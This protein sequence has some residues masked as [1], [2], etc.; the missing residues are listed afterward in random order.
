MAPLKRAQTSVDEDDSS[1]SSD[2]NSNK[3][4]RTSESTSGFPE[5]EENNESNGEE[6]E[7]S[8]M[9]LQSFETYDAEE[10]DE[11]TLEQQAT[12][13]ILERYHT[14]ESNVPSD[15][16]I[17][18]RVDCFNFMCHKHFS[19]ELSPLI[20]FIVG[21]NGSG[22]SAI[23]TALTLCLGAKASITNRGQSL[24][25]FI[26]EGEESATIIV[27]IKNQGDGAYMP[28]E[29]GKSII[30]ERSFTKSGS[31]GFKIKNETGK[32]VSTKKVD[33]DAITDFF[34]LQIDNPMN[35][36][37]Q[38]MARQFLSSSSPAEKYKFFVKGVQLEQLDHDYRLIEESVDQIKEKLDAR[39]G[40]LNILKA[41]KEKAQR[42]LELSDQ[43]NNLRL[44]VRN[45]RGQM[46]W[47]QVEEQEK[48][49]DNIDMDIAE[50][51]RQIIAAESDV[52]NLDA[53]YEAAQRELA[54]ASGVLN[55]T[56][57]SLERAREEKQ[58]IQALRDKEMSDHHDL[59]AE[60]RQIGEH[61]KSAQARIDKLK[62]DISEEERRMADVDG[63]NFAQRH[64]ELAQ[65]RAKAKEASEKHTQHQAGATK[66]HEAI[67][68]A[69]ENLK[70][71]IA[72]VHK[73]K[74]EI[75]QAEK[76][77]RSLSK[78]RGQSNAGFSDKMPQLLAAIA[79]ENS[80]GRRPVGP[81]AHHVRLMKPEWSAVIEQSLNNSLN[82][83]IVTSKRDMNILSRIM[84][85]VNCVC[86][87]LI[88][89]D[90]AIDTSAH[91]PDRRFDTILRVLEIDD[92]LVRRQLII[93]HGIEQIV[94]IQNVE[95]AS[96][97][98]F[99][100][101]RLR[102]VKRCLCIDSRDRRRGVT[103]AYGRTGEPSQAP[104]APYTGR[105]RMRSDIDSQIRLQEE[106]VQAL[107]SQLVDMELRV[108][109]ARTELQGCK[110][111]LTQY[112][113]EED[114]LKIEAQRLEDHADD[115]ED[116]LEK[117]RVE[118]GHLDALKNS[119]AEAE[120]EKT[121]SN[122]SYNDSNLAMQ[123]I[124]TNL[125]NYGR[126][127]AAKEN[128]IQPLEENVRIAENEY[129]K[130]EEHRRV[131]LAQKNA[132]YERVKDLNQIR[133]ARIADKEALVA[134]VVSY[135]EQ[136]SI[137]SARVPIDE[138]ETPSSLEKKL[139]KLS[140]DLKRFEQ[141]MGASRD[142]LAAELLKA[143][144]ALASAEKQFNEL[145]KLE[146]IFKH[147]INYRRER[148]KNFRAHISSRAKAQFTYLLSERSFRGR[149]LTD[150][151][152]KLLDLQVEPD[153][154]KNSA[155]RGAKTL[156]GGEKS[157]SQICLLLSLWEAMGS[158]IRCLD[159]FDVYM[160]QIN[161]KSSIDMLMMAARRSI[162]RQFILITPGS[163]ADIS[164]APDVRVKELA[165]PE[166][167]QSTLTFRQT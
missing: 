102:C 10:E 133:E 25:S 150:H 162:G 121:L 155:G 3:R 159:E 74:S 111:A 48:R 148:W 131:V 50:I 14:N 75:E 107:K 140:S 33:L 83:F 118:D 151:E 143:S 44:R 105:P 4:R 35:V 18:E 56:K 64:E 88:G 117:D 51:D 37:S 90:G 6:R 154:T 99:E 63:G 119:L 5:S 79:H 115:L 30:V 92:D 60:Q 113:Y 166:R 13:A 2:T 134:L 32:I 46:A 77:L 27:R 86:P 127:L 146:Q 101:E 76:L 149:L 22:K 66:F 108:A 81:V 122:N 136:A 97:T 116:A 7:E 112:K 96:A 12:Q 123:G 47:A 36:L 82:S 68:K 106:N 28:N 125:K 31:S 62:Q 70:Q 89:S 128:D 132:A 129:A 17:I 84:Q 137:V 21:K 11:D 1:S 109:S 104:I 39:R 59:Q 158:P 164:L 110:N 69:E 147:T 9:P 141:Q 67:R 55:N 29:Y 167:G 142:E 49:R 38:D 98:L 165:E 138:G 103:L 16:G 41:D 57:E 45:I 40:D 19:V 20:N 65:R 8:A 24:K 124:K 73:H 94:L 157:F 126:Q 85:R 95:E 145:E 23:L 100:G 91:E 71:T 160:D 72:P 80:F 93:N 26:K 15:H 120:G 78:D 43:R 114:N 54:T 87:I 135:C 163:R 58:E 42:R 53:R 34:N 139:E 130:V 52:G 61:V 156:S 161:R 152:A 153:I 144:K